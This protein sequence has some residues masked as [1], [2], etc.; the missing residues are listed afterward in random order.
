MTLQICGRGTVQVSWLACALGL[1]TNKTATGGYA[2]IFEVV[3]CTHFL[4]EVALE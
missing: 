3:S 1:R 2:A 4:I